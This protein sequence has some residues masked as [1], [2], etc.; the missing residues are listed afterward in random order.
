M[1]LGVGFLIVDEF[2]RDSFSVSLLVRPAYD[3]RLTVAISLIAL[4]VFTV[5][6]K[7]ENLHSEVRK[8]RRQYLGI[9]EVLSPNEPVD[10][11]KLLATCRTVK[12]L[13]LSGTKAGFLGDSTVRESLANPKRKCR[14]TIL[15]ANPYSEAIKTRYQC[16]EPDTYEVGLEGI[17]RRLIALGRII[18]SLPSSKM[19]AIDVRVFDCYP[20]ISIVQADNDLYSTVYGFRLRGSDCPKLHSLKGG[21]YAD[22]LLKHFQK[23]YENSVPLLDW[24]KAHHPNVVAKK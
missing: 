15:L 16:D 4:F 11:H 10:F 22:F 2:L 13:T 8:S 12:L 7:I 5:T 9:A 21:D 24:I 23:V 19:S 20:T 3:I 1:Y 14:I 18:S 17:E 6:R